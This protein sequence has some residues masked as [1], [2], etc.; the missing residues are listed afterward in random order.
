[1]NKSKETELLLSVSFSN[2]QRSRICSVGTSTLLEHIAILPLKLCFGSH[3]HLLSTHHSESILIM[4]PA[5]SAA[6][7]A[8][9]LLLQQLRFPRV[10]SQTRLHSL[11]LGKL[12]LNLS[13]EQVF[14]TLLTVRVLNRDGP[15]TEIEVKRGSGLNLLILYFV[16]HLKSIC[17]GQTLQGS[18]DLKKIRK[19]SQTGLQEGYKQFGKMQT[20]Q[21]RWWCVQ[22]GAR[23]NVLA[24][25]KVT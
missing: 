24:G 17:P 4:P 12:Q 13:T 19:Y 25:H 1:M 11:T 14:D 7:F 9:L 22:G 18:Q 23:E 2:T 20:V 21:S 16:K 3:G 10:Q 8:E 6:S 5:C 15:S